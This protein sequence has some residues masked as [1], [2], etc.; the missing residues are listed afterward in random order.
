M[1]IQTLPIKTIPIKFLMFF[2]FSTA[3]SASAYAQSELPSTSEMLLQVFGALV[4]IV[5]LIVGAAW[6]TKRLNLVHGSQFGELK[7]LSTLTLG[8]KEKIVLVDACGKKL[9]LGV[10]SQGVN[11]LQDLSEGVSDAQGCED[12]SLSVSET[13]GDLTKK[14]TPQAVKKAEFSTFLKNIISS[15][16]REHKN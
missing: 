16:L 3:F 5:G 11:F 7:V 9:L 13:E 6:L 14:D 2:L 1:P 8:R 15:D 12:T 10:G 4:L